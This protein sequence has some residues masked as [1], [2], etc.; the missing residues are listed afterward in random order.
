M[1]GV[2][3]RRGWYDVQSSANEAPSASFVKA[4]FSE[5]VKVKIVRKTK[6]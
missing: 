6:Y 5:A 4:L 1:S 2:K 3:R